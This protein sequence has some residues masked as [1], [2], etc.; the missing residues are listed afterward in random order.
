MN[1]SAHDVAELILQS[2]PTLHLDAAGQS[3]NWGLDSETLSRLGRVIRGDWITA[4]TGAG[5]STILCGA[6]ARRHY[7]VC[8]DQAEIAR[9]RG[10]ISEHHWPDQLVPLVASSDV[11]LP[12]LAAT[13]GGELLDLALIDGAHRYPFPIIDWH[14]FSRV[15]RPE[16]LMLVDDIQI[17]S[18]GLLIEYLKQD[19]DWRLEEVTGKT[20][21]F[22]KLREEA[23]V[24][25]WSG[26]SIN[27]PGTSS[28][29]P[30]PSVAKLRE[31]I[32]L[33]LSH[34]LRRRWER[35][36]K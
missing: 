28:G 31:Q 32:G 4:E 6:C 36:R 33:K 2:K 9:I 35:F 22:R 13:L 17:P 34:G 1:P 5:I 30:V 23:P 15:L 16:G 19:A 21:W 20:A 18:V 25:D 14:Y 10:F 11:A 26:Q 24:N 12:G 8:P 29:D 27:R 3:V 7:V